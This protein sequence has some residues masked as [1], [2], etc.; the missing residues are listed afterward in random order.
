MNCVENLMRHS[1]TSLCRHHRLSLW[2]SHNS[3]KPPSHIL[4]LDLIYIDWDQYQPF[5][6]QLFRRICK[7]W[8]SNNPN[9][10]NAQAIVCGPIGA[11]DICRIGTTTYVQISWLYEKHDSSHT[12]TFAEQIDSDE[13]DTISLGSDD[14]TDWWADGN[15]IIARL[16][17][18]LTHQCWSC[19]ILKPKSRQGRW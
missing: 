12:V 15:S 3:C 9:A 10:T 16:A 17:M 1:P 5:Y 2:T 13:D 6:Q 7:H 4:L 14:S 8:E 18:S 19:F 11:T